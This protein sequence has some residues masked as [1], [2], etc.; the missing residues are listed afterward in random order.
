MSSEGRGGGFS[1]RGSN[2][3]LLLLGGILALTLAMAF[4]MGSNATKLSPIAIKLN[5][6]T[7]RGQAASADQ[8]QRFGMNFRQ[9]FSGKFQGS[10]VDVEGDGSKT[11]RIEWTGVD[12]PFAATIAESGEIID[13]LRELGF[14]HL[15]ITDG[16]R[17]TW[18]VDLKN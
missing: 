7:P 4:G 15:I 5:D 14:K 9:K 13:D 10:K 17:S 1:R 18:D 6:P 8:R 11:L 2:K 3:R 12:R 16:H